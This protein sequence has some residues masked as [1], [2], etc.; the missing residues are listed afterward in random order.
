[1]KEGLS[2]LEL[3]ALKKAEDAYSGFSVTGYLFEAFPW[4]NISFGR[5]YSHARA[6]KDTGRFADGHLMRTSTV[7]KVFEKDE[8]IA[9]ATLN[10]IYVCVTFRVERSL[11]IAHFD[12]VSD[13][14]IH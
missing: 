3:L 10:S 9:V 1:M 7:M 5:V 12:S 4:G 2:P 6:D 8:F 14:V 13:V 11:F